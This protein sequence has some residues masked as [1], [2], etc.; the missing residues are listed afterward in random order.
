[1]DPQVISDPAQ[2]RKN[3]IH[4]I[5]RIVRNPYH[6]INIEKSIYN[7]TI[8]EC[9]KR[10]IMKSWSNLHYVTIY[11]SKFKM[12]YF[13]IKRPEIL[14]NIHNKTIKCQN[15]AY[16]KHTDLLPEK[17]KDKIQDKKIRLENKY[18]PKIEA[19]TD[20][21]LIINFKPVPRMNL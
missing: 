2:F 13:N 5:G 7:F 18:F 17:W 10:N 21:V 19:S 11:I 8:E 14:K 3:I 12:I 6:S 15:I 1:M 16:M 20:N 9:D 4:A